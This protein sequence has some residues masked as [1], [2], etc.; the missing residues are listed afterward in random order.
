MDDKTVWMR[1][2]PARVRICAETRMHNRNC[3]NIVFILQVRE[4]LAELPHQ[5]HAFIHNRPARKRD[6]VCIII[7]LLKYTPCYIQFA[8]KI[9]PPVYLF[10]TF[11]K[12]LHNTRHTFHRLM[13]KNIRYNWHFPPSKE[14]KP[15]L[16]D[17]YLEHFFRL[18]LFQFILREEEHT[19]SIIPLLAKFN[20]KRL[21]RFLEKFMRNLEQNADAVACLPLCVFPRTVFQLFHNIQSTR[22]RIVCL[23]SLNIYD[24]ANTAVIVFKTRVVQAP[25][26]MIH[27]LSCLCNHIILNLFFLHANPPCR[28]PRP[29]IVKQA[30]LPIQLTCH[31]QWHHHLSVDC[32]VLR[33]LTMR[34]FL[35]IK[36][37]GSAKKLLNPLVHHNYN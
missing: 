8:V 17:D 28:L 18:V 32:F 37:K 6:H 19:D 20:T 7:T 27:G 21:Y 2:H 15:L 13:P 22:H 1:P 33:T 11:N 25:L 31:F 5:K 9:K 3:R 14:F 29:I 23:V 34:T 4:K 35:K 36:K 30:N 12:R 26:I 16:L 10:R 24:S